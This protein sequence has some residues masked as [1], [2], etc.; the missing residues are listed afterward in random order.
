MG[1]IHINQ[2]KGV[3]LDIWKDTDKTNQPVSCSKLKRT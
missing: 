3:R 1:K 2:G